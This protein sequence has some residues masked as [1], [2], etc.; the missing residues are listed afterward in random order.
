MKD[1]I[2]AARAKAIAASRARANESK[3]KATQK[4]NPNIER[5]RQMAQSAESQIMA[6]AREAATAAKTIVTGETFVEKASKVA[7]TAKA[8][9]D[10]ARAMKDAASTDTV[11]GGSEAAR[12]TRKLVTC[13]KANTK[14]CLRGTY[15]T[16][17]KTDRKQLD[18]IARDA[19]KAFSSQLAAKA[20]LGEALGIHE[21][22]QAK[23]GDAASETL[24]AMSQG[25]THR[26]YYK[27]LVKCYEKLVPRCLG[28]AGK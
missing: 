10:K 2:N 20:S 21:T 22:Q 7:Q 23:L 9:A 13:F 18:T 25:P 28:V 17:S 3:A 16:L 11:S 19:A 14:G 5:A 4:A 27:T 6:K 26:K 1:R 24:V 15:K 12:I 8:V